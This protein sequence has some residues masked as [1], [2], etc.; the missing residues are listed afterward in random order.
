[1]EGEL[2]P[3]VY[4][5]LMEEGKKRPRP[6]GTRFSDR[7]ILEI[8]LWAAAHDRPTSWACEAKN[9]PADQR[10]KDLPSQS[11]MS[12]RLRTL[13]V[14]LFM[15]C[16]LDRFRQSG[17]M[18]ALVRILDSK[19]L[20][21]GCYSKD[22]DA[23]WGQAAAAKARGYKIF[24]GWSTCVVP[25]AWTLGSMNAADSEMGI[26]LVP[27]LTGAAYVLGDAGHDS[28]PLHAACERCG[29]QLVAPRRQPQTKLGHCHHENGRLRSIEMLEWPVALGTSA[30]PFGRALYAM[31]PQIERTYGNLCA[32]GGGLQPLPSWVRTPHRVAMWVAA[33]LL[34]NALRRCKNARVAA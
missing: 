6:Q 4:R 25:D 28:N 19:P 24:C 11:T 34:I 14:R 23:H 30:S 16:L 10:W 18:S 8:Y 3:E 12:D 15:Q 29:C 7:R 9:W 20:C 21:V 26:K 13:G 2:W 5:L 27:Q 33:K 1:M 17:Q 22:C 31:R 32:F